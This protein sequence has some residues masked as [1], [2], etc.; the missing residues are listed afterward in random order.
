MIQIFLSRTGKQDLK[1]IEYVSRNIFYKMKA[2]SNLLYQG[3]ILFS[4]DADDLTTRT[5][6]LKFNVGFP[7]HKWTFEVH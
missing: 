1:V 5:V 7:K 4:K 3:S 6:Y 2:Y